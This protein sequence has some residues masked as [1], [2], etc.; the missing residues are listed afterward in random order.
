MDQATQADGSH[1]AISRVRRQILTSVSRL[2]VVEPT[3]RGEFE[4]LSGTERDFAARMPANQRRQ[5]CDCASCVR[6][7]LR[8]AQRAIPTETPSTPGIRFVSLPGVRLVLATPE[9]RRT[10]EAFYAEHPDQSWVVCGCDPCTLH[11]NFV[12]AWARV[13]QFPPAAGGCRAQRN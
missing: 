7:A 13:I 9:D 4:P 10:L 11:R 1:L 6:H 5:Q 8:L 2:V 3:N 12:R